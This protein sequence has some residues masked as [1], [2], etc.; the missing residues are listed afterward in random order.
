MKCEL[1]EGTGWIV[2]EGM[3]A[4]LDSLPGKGPGTP[5]G[6]DVMLDMMNAGVYDADPGYPCPNCNGKRSSVDTQYTLKFTAL[7]SRHSSL[8]TPNYRQPLIIP[9]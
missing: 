6:D 2:S 3:Q 4:A 9:R 5:S 7:K 8:P 1:C